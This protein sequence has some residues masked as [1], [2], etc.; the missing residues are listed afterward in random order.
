MRRYTALAMTGVMALTL[1]TGCASPQKA[2]E[3]D[4]TA[5]PQTEAQGA[6]TK[7]ESEPNAGAADGTRE[8][9]NYWHIHTGDEAKVEDD[10]IAAYNASQDKYEVVGLS[11]NDQQKLIVAMSSDE[12]PDVIFS[13]NSNLTTYYF[14]GLLKDLQEYADRDQL[15]MSQW[16]K[17]SIEACTFDGDLYAIPESGGSQIQMFYNKDLLAEAGYSEPPATMEELYEMAEKITKLD[18][19]GNIEVLGYLLFP[20]ASAR[21]ELIYAFGGRWWDDE[22]NLTPESQGILDSLHMNMQVREKYGV[23]K[24]QAFVGTANTNRYTE[25][26]M[27]FTGNQAFRFDGAWLTA[28]IL[29]NNPDLNYGIA[30]VPG[31]KA[32]PENQGISRYEAGTLAMPVN[33]KC[34]EGAWDFIK[35]AGGFEGSKI[36]DIGR[37]VTPA[38]LDLM[39][40]PD[41]RAIP[42]LDEFIEATRLENG[43]NY[44]KIKD[45]AKYVSLIDNALDLVYNGYQTPEEA[46]ADLAAQCKSLE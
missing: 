18:A 46:I 33:A 13:S 17:K 1:L 2:A 32:H 38:R 36:M 10:L 24:V 41:I 4:T 20:L 19:D 28:M 16:T 27:F 21:Q 39:D 14:N 35:F 22:G 26:D 30:M 34:K 5:A 6:E 25:Q 45:Y 9:V 42:G 40:D 31:T 12:G 43:I 15:D 37:S 3:N 44:P 11:M 29:N 7:T 23:E 8:V